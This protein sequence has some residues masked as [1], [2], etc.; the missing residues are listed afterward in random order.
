MFLYVVIM[1][2][3][4]LA[5]GI[6][7]SVLVK[8]NRRVEY[9]TLDKIGVV[10][11]IILAAAY[12]CFAPFYMFIGMITTPHRDGFWGLVGIVICAISGSAACVAG[13][14]VGGSVALR[15]RGYKV[16]SFIAQFAGVVAIIL[17]FGLY[18]AFVGTLISP[19][20]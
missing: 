7:P 18:A 13:A 15:R 6:L 4:G 20:N 8:R 10:T 3:L 5:G 1:A 16:V 14:S 9:T 19:L 11:N 2:I 17:T 12:T